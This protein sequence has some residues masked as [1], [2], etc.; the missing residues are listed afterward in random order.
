MRK[1]DVDDIVFFCLGDKM[2][3]SPQVLILHCEIVSIDFEIVFQIIFL[4]DHL[5]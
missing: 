2:R 1:H 5:R 4:R 3:T